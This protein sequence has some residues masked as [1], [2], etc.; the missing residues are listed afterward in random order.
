MGDPLTWIAIAS[1]ATAATS[2][3]QAVQA[4][5]ASTEA[6]RETRRVAGAFGKAEEELTGQEQ[7]AEKRR[8][9][10]QARLQRQ[11][12][13]A[14]AGGRRSTILTGPLGLTGEPEVGGKTLLGA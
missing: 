6:K 13:G 4:K 14:L 9:R 11:A 5:S 3:V 10:E 1:A 7:A 2:G 12:R 8:Q